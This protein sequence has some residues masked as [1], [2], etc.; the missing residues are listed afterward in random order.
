MFETE[1]DA[2]VDTEATLD[3]SCWSTN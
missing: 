3:G 1:M 2:S